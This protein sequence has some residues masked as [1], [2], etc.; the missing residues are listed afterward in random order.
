[1]TAAYSTDLRRRIVEAHQ[2]GE[3]SY[4]TLAKRFDVSVKTVQNYV[5]L[6]RRTGSVEPMAHS[7]GRAG[8]KLFE[9]HFIEIEAWL[10]EQ[11]LLYWREVADKLKTKHDIDIHPSQLCRKMK[12]RGMR[13][14]K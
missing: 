1:M 13:R 10:E 11:P 7:G 12:Q 2:R 8:Q 4:V 14:K 3:G 5:E 6:Y 9:H